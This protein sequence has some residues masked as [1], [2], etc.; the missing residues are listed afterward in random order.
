MMCNFLCG[1]NT[2]FSLRL[3]TL[4]STY[5]NS[6]ILYPSS[7]EKEKKENDDNNDKKTHQ[8]LRR[9]TRSCS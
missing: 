4:P 8:I 9:E 3:L 7:F 1:K 2:Y 6:R 5:R